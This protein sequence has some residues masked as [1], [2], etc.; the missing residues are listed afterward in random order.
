[1]QFVESLPEQQVQPNTHGAKLLHLPVVEA[2]TAD[3]FDTQHAHKMCTALWC[4]TA[5]V[6]TVR[7]VACV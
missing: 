4:S 2:T 5:A 3:R 6:P 7:N 1:M